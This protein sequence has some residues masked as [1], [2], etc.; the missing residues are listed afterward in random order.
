[1]QMRPKATAAIEEADLVQIGILGIGEA[2]EHYDHSR[3]MQFE[4][5]AML[6]ARWAVLDE[7]RK[8]DWVPRYTREKFAAKFNNDGAGDAHRAKKLAAARSLSGRMNEEKAD[9]GSGSMFEM[10]SLQTPVK[11]KNGE[12]YTTLGDSLP[13]PDGD[14][15]H[16]MMHEEMKAEVS[17]IVESLPQSQNTVL[18]MHYYQNVDMQ[19]IAKTMGISPSRV[20]QLHRSAMVTMK[21][22]LRDVVF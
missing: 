15:L 2:I 8:L 5:Y 22:R 12:Q 13:S 21:E 20:S 1:R 10:L 3:G 7:L 16:G 9:H 6:R 19:D 17:R 14:V 4:T 11:D 18:R